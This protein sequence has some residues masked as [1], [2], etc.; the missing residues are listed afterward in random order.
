MR[1]GETEPA[2][3][4]R[5]VRNQACRNKFFE[6]KQT[7]KDSHPHIVEWFDSS[8]NRALQTDIIE[9]CFKKSGKAWVLDLDKPF[10]QESKKRCVGSRGAYINL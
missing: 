5:K 9:Q 8:V 1:A 6:D 7:I 2:P 4:K 3:K 10:F